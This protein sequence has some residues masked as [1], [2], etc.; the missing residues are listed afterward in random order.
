MAGNL[1]ISWGRNGGYYLTR[2]RICLGK[3]A[4]TYLPV[5]IDDLMRAYGEGE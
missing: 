3:V 5:E 2:W 1:S 4:I